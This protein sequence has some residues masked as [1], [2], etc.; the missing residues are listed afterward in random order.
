MAQTTLGKDDFKLSDQEFF[1]LKKSIRLRLEIEIQDTEY[2]DN[3]MTTKQRREY[4][5]QAVPKDEILHLGLSQQVYN[6]QDLSGVV[7][8]ATE[9]D[10]QSVR[11]VAVGGVVPPHDSNEKVLEGV[12][13]PERKKSVEFQ[14]V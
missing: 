3:K 5:L 6:D 9:P 11:T 4:L 2:Q 8:E 10:T 12:G 14:D 1:S 7:A 13:K